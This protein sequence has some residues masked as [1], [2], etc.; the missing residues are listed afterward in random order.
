M[1]FSA[2][3]L[4]KGR[5]QLTPVTW[6][7]RTF[8]RPRKPVGRSVFPIPSG[9]EVRGG[10]R[11]GLQQTLRLPPRWHHARLL[12]ASTV[13]PWVLPHSAADRSPGASAAAVPP[14][15]MGLAVQTVL[16]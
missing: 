4:L 12:P 2:E 11:S 9:T 6:S 13:V 8:P 5:P 14:S 1:L 10:W 3:E 7:P 15:Q 16:P